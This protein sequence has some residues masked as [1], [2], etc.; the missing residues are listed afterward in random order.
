METCLARCEDNIQSALVLDGATIELHDRL[1]FINNKGRRGGAM[2]MYGRSRVIFKNNSILNFE[3]NKGDD[4]GGALYIQAPGSPRARVDSS[5]VNVHM[6]VFE[7]VNPKKD[8]DDWDTT[9]IFKYNT[10]PIG[11]SI[12]ATTL[13]DCGKIDKKKQKNNI[14]EWKFVKFIPNQ[15]DEVATDTMEICAT[16]EDWNVAPGEV[17]DARVNLTD[18]VGN[19]VD[20]IVKVTV[21][22]GNSV[23]LKSS[24]LFL[25]TDSKI[26]SIILCGDQE[27]NFSVELDSVGNELIS[28]RIDN[29][30]KKCYPG[31]EHSNETLRCECI[32]KTSKAARGV[33]HCG[34][35]NKTVF[36]KK[37]FW[38]GPL[39][40]NETFFTYFCP[41]GYCN[42]H[43]NTLEQCYEYLK[44]QMCQSGRNQSSTLCGKCSDNHSIA[45]GSEECLTSCKDWNLFYL[46]LIGAVVIVLVILIMLINVDFFT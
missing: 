42:S 19:P 36:I 43:E 8:Y 31:F 12:Y 28:T 14:F 11:K 26:G 45:F 38:A 40:G 44:D 23:N 32:N 17:F 10:A 9:V 33:S 41:I 20:G 39:S 16:G 30:L 27:A 13:K 24:N 5:I 3:E 4:K 22:S 15:T 18:E 29:V 1:D 46:I 37:G 21:I 2:A 7:Y 34:P 6:C 35:K 25:S